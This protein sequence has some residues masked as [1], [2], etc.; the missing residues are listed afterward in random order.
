MIAAITQ[1]S[2]PIDSQIYTFA[3]QQLFYEFIP[4]EELESE[5]PTTLF[6]DQVSFLILLKKYACMDLTPGSRAHSLPGMNPS[7]CIFSP[8]RH[9]VPVIL[10]ASATQYCLSHMLNRSA[11]QARCVFLQ[12]IKL[13]CEIFVFHTAVVAN[14]KN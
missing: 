12:V 13:D 14:I 9:L 8:S 3:P 4:V 6:L 1:A 5:S 2:D 10:P 7:R 11:L